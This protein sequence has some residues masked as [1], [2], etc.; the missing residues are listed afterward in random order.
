MRAAVMATKSGWL[1]FPRTWGVA[2]REERY[3]RAYPNVPGNSTVL[4]RFLWEVGSCEP[5]S[6]RVLSRLA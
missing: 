4:P 2:L 6:R 3:Q 5:R 1:D